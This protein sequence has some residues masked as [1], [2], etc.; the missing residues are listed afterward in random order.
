M[1]AV[2][3][4]GLP[5]SGKTL[6]TSLFVKRGFKSLTMGDVI[7][8]YAE[9]KGITPDEAAVLIR[10]E[11]GMRAV[12]SSLGITRGHD[13]VVIDGLRS[14]EEAE[15]L[16]EMFG[17]FYLVYVVAS[18]RT[19]L[20]RLQ[21]RGRSDDP[22]SLAEFAMREYRELKFGVAS[23]LSRA[24]FI[25]VNEDKSVEELESEIDAIVRTL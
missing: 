5:G 24:D 17:R 21:A 25:I 18:R 3:I 6:I 4:A 20:K 23:L 10:L 8:K 15:A 9:T 13:K 2:G 1:A 22:A 12:V 14:L 16:E 7:R 11:R 19:R